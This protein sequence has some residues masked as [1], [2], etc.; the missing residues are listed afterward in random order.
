MDKE[1]E[2]TCVHLGDGAY[3]SFD[4]YQIWLSANHHKNTVVALEPEVLKSFIEYCKRYF[5]D[6]TK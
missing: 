1:Q 3:A 4:G 5:P 2:K 6:I